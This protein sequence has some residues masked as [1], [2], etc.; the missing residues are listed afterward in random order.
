[1]VTKT[2]AFPSRFWKPT[3]LPAR[4]LELKIAKLQLDK[5]GKDQQE[6]YCLYFKGQDKQLVMNSTNWDRTAE[7]C[8]ADSDTWTGKS[9]VLYPDKTPFGGK[10]VDCIRVRPPRPPQPPQ[11]APVPRRPESEP[12]VDDPDD[13]GFQPEDAVEFENY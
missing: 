10:M 6:K 11:A 4:G 3:D 1:M 2:E 5:I 7:F 13:P 12:P 8:G 9:I